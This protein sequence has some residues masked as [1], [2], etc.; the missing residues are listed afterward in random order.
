MWSRPPSVRKVTTPKR[1][2]IEFRRGGWESFKAAVHAAALAVREA[3]SAVA[4]R[5]F[6]AWHRWWWRA[7]GSIR[8]GAGAYRR[9][10]KGA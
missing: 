1:E 10:I 4:A 2:G 5:S 9:V 6:H 3:V 7:E 8:F